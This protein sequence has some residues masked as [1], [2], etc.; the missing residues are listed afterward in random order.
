M[1]GLEAQSRGRQQGRNYFKEMLFCLFSSSNVRP[2]SKMRPIIIWLSIVLCTQGQNQLESPNGGEDYLPPE[3][4]RGIGTIG[5]Q[6]RNSVK[7]SEPRRRYPERSYYDPG[8]AFRNPGNN[9]EPSTTSVPRAN[10]PRQGS[11]QY[12]PYPDPYLTNNSSRSNVIV[13]RRTTTTST[14][15]TTQA[16]T[17][18]PGKPTRSPFDD[19]NRYRVPQANQQSDQVRFVNGRPYRYVL[20]N[21]SRL[22]RLYS[23]AT[24]YSNCIVLTSDPIYDVITFTLKMDAT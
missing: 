16:T 22:S 14:R 13:T 17:A 19:P 1:F 12:E 10:L 6:P 7:D 21:F 3:L 18:R 4:G 15:R 23:F 2:L 5:N 9:F 20:N 24:Q 11:F 8:S